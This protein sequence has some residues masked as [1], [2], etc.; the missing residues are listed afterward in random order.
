MALFGTVSSDIHFRNRII[1]GDMRIDQR[2]VGTSVGTASGAGAYTLDRWAID[3]SQTSKFTIQQNAGAVTPPNGFINYIGVTSSSAYSVVAADYFILSQNIEGFN[4]SDLNWGTASAANVTLSFW[5][6]S[7]LTGNFGGCFQN[8]A[9]D[10]SYPFG[11]TISSANT[12]E[13]KTITVTGDTTGTWIG[14]TNGTGVKVRFGLGFGSN[15]VGTA[16][17]WAGAYIGYPTGSTSVVGTNGATWYV[18]GVQLE[19]GS[20]AT[21]FERRPYGTELA[22]CQ[23]YFWKSAQL[24]GAYA[25]F[26]SG[27]GQSSTAAWIYVKYPATMRASPTFTFNDLLVG[28]LTA[29]PLLTS[30]GSS[31]YS[32]DSALL[33]CNASGGGL[34]GN[35]PYTL[36]ANVSSTASFLAASAEL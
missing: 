18:T 35:L 21:P 17:T 13:Q 8:S 27:W 30:I 34:T 33:I 32:A 14:A 22:L 3:Y 10:R 11:Y 28:N 31:G 12:W 1:N 9:G 26:G 25:A 6:R 20:V 4:F 15:F 36:G 16:N 24:S 19:A 29:S 5:V 23:R 7:S 2:N